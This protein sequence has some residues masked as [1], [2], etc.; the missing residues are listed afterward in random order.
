MLFYYILNDMYEHNKPYIIIVFSKIKMGRKSLSLDIEK[1]LILLRLDPRIYPLDVVYSAAY[2]FI[3]K[4]YILLDGDPNKKIF[5]ELRL[6]TKTGKKNQL[7]ELGRDFLNEL[8]NYGFYKK[9]SDKNR[10]IRETLLQT[11]LF[12]NTQ[13]NSEKDEFEELEE[14]DFDSEDSESIIVPWEEKHDNQGQ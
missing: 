3:E 6:K 11:S 8:L 7:E 5:V 13:D 4:A 9:H 14:I 12:A 10:I 2:V 1:N